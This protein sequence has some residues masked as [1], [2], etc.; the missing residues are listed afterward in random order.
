MTGVKRAANKSDKT[1]DEIQ[2]GLRRPL[3]IAK[4]KIFY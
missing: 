1:R 3:G 4:S 2:S